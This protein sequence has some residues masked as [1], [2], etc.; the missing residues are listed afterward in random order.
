MGAG[1]HLTAPSWETQLAPLWRGSFCPA[2]T[3]GPGPEELSGGGAAGEAPCPA[4][5]PALSAP[6]H[7]R[8]GAVQVEHNGHQLA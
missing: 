7:R 6:E 2:I 8:R 4:T 5:G 3:R 1:L